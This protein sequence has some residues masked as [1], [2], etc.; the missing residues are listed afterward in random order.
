M[1]EIYAW[2]PWFTELSRKIADRGPEFLVDRARQV[3]W[4]ETDR[5]PP[6]AIQGVGPDPFTFLYYIAAR[7]RTY[8][9]RRVI[10][11]SISTI[12]GIE[13]FEDKNSEDACIFPYPPAVTALFH[14]KDANNIHLL[15]RLFSEAVEGLA[16]IKGSDF[17]AALEIRG[18]ATRKLTQA[19]FLTNP[20]EFLPWDDIISTLPLDVADKNKELHWTNYIEVLAAFCK[21]FP[22][23]KPYEINMFAWL[24]LDKR[25][26]LG[27]PKYFQI[28]TK[29]DFN[30][31]GRRERQ[32]QD[33]V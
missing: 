19:L 8:A 30:A 7:S 22:G 4:S 32:H 27:E 6:T 1:K 29:T 26:K 33:E 3:T 5:N 14:M 10:L 2:V 18:I 28:V 21:A 11:P 23:C 25:L 24:V 31:K 20:N 13:M 15:W 16:S 12:F 9:A 17:D